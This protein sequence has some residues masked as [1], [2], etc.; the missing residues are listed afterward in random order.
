MFRPDCAFDPHRVYHQPSQQMHNE[1]LFAESAHGSP[2]DR[3]F[4]RPASLQPVVM[5]PGARGERLP[6]A[7]STDFTPPPLFV[8]STAAR[9]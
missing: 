1:G 5:F 2:G 4:M 6:E 9:Y 8:P 3:L 7:Y